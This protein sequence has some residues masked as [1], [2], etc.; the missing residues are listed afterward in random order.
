MKGAIKI[1]TCRAGVEARGHGGTASEKRHKRVDGEICFANMLANLFYV[2]IFEDFFSLQATAM[3]P[4]GGCR[5]GCRIMRPLFLARP[6]RLLAHVAAAGA[7]LL[8]H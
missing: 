3:A 1:V 4:W 2:R 8:G 6:R 5:R 7:F